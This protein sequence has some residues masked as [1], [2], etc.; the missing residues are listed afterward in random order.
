MNL[1]QSP[2]NLEQEIYNV[3]FCDEGNID[4]CVKSLNDSIFSVKKEGKFISE[5]S[6]IK[7]SPVTVELRTVHLSSYKND[8]LSY[9][10]Q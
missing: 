9:H 7:P 10:H 3:S 1:E 8:P 6:K 5:L 2:V 4:S